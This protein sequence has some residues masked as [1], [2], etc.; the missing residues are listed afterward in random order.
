MTLGYKSWL[1]YLENS[2]YKDAS[3]FLKFAILWLSFNAYLNEVYSETIK[4]DKNKVLAFA[5]VNANVDFF[6]NSTNLVDTSKTFQ[7]TKNNKR[8][9]VEDLQSRDISKRKYLNF[10]N[11]NNLEAYLMVIYQIR[12][13][14]FHGDKIPFD[15]DDTNLVEWAFY[16]FKDFWGKYLSY[17]NIEV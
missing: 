17:S 10:N 2:I 7:K 11:N 1:D 4:G 5:G 15:P 16:S 9:F 6:N 8:L 13:N 3:S 12:C 14:F